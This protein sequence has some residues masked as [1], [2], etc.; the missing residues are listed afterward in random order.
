VTGRGWRVA[1]DRGGTFTDVVATGPDGRVRVSKLLSGEGVEVAALRALFGER[2]GELVDELRLG[3]T[4]ATNALLTRRGSPTALVVTRGH[5]DL[6]AIRHQ[7]RPRIFELFVRK[8]EPLCARVIEVDERTL[9]D[10]TVERE[11]DLP[12][13]RPALEELRAG[14]IRSVAV[15]L[16]HGYLFPEHERHVGALA[17]EVGFDRVTLSSEIAPEI[18]L[19]ARAET[20]AVDGFVTP[21]LEAWIRR[22]LASLPVAATSFMKSSGGLTEAE[23]F[24]GID[25]VLSGPAGGVVACA[26]IGRQLGLSAVL[27]FDMGGTSTDVCRW[28]GELER[29]S[30]LEVGG[31][32]L[33]APVL[34]IVTVAAGGGS[35]LRDL[36]GR[37][38]AGPDSSGATPGPACYGRGGPASLTDANVALG[39]LAPDLFPPVFGPEADAPLDVVAARD[40]LAP[41]GDPAE[42]AAGFVA[43]ANA[44]M[45]AAIS[46]LSTERG[47]DPA[48]HALVAFGGAAPQHACAIAELLGIR[49]VV[50]HPLAGV[51]SACGIDQADRL[52]TRSLPVMEVWDEGLP[53]RLGPRLAAAVEA[54]RAEVGDPSAE[55]ALR[56][57]LRYRGS[58][59]SLPARDAAHFEAAH[60]RLFGFRRPGPVEAVQLR[61]EARS[62]RAVELGVAPVLADASWPSPV[63]VRSVG[64]ADAEGGVAW[65]AT[66]VF[67]R[68]ELPPGRRDGPLLLA[69]P[70]TTILVDPGW[71]AEVDSAGRVLLTAGARVRRPPRGPARDPVRLELF[72]R[73]FMSIA[74]RMGETLRRVA[75]SVNIKERLDYSCAVFDASG[76]LVANA[77][78]IPVHLGAMGETVRALAARLGPELRPGRSW[79]VN[80]PFEG[81]SHLPDITVI[82]PVFAPGERVPFAWVANRG[83]HADVGGITPGSMPPFSR[84]LDEEG[85]RL[86]DLLLVDGSHWRR[87]AVASALATGPHP[88]RD[89]DTCVAD[90]QAQVAANT[91]GARLLCELADREGADAVAAYMG[92]IQDNGDEV[93]Q[94]WLRGWVGGARRFADA[95]DDGTPIRVALTVRPAG[96]RRELVVDFEGTGP[97]TA[98][99]LNAPPAVVRAAVLYVLRCVVDREIPLNEG[100]LRAVRIRIPEGSLLRPPPGAAV[101]GGNVETS[102]RL[103]DVL[104][105][106]LGVAA[107][108]QGTMNNLTFGDAG[109]GYYETVCGGAGAGE[110]RAGTDAVHTHMTNT[111]ITD[112]EVLERRQPV[113]VREFGLR[114]GSGGAGRWPGGRGVRRVL[115]F[116]APLQVSLLSQRRERPPFGLAGGHSGASGRASLERADGPREELAGC[117]AIQVEPG[118]RLVLETPGGGGFGQPSPPPPAPPSQTPPTGD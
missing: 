54:A 110:G 78:H 113:L 62:G 47:H 45:A 28:A 65:H 83:H 24:A 7:A 23:T 79:A 102:Q 70:V 118:D 3:T 38:R 19:V 35:V 93:V 108:S 115:E 14:G 81:G 13:L 103:V 20:A 95:M 49:T 99:N 51:L 18:G 105:G 21:V 82:T 90:L 27:G 4:V 117:F 5:R 43:V 2:A 104:L 26:H 116:R 66:P 52:A 86:R 73:R 48:E 91:L 50:I 76:H 34:D 100:C 57:D 30:T 16:V 112:T 114:D 97:A 80:D 9:P 87:D 36:D 17:R 12:R 6:L 88:A 92:H 106:A 101:V 8:V 85:V 33:R 41:F 72:W 77:P 74:T 53:D 71:A 32:R 22:L 69:D 25:A 58:D 67:R 96:E 60:E 59:T 11:P 40:V 109:R 42:A 64:F 63:A 98:G 107:A 29:R 44:T 31:A 15:A 68:R 75:W 46:E 10:G 89:P 37:F 111:R 1:I 39:R 84:S 56:W 55:V 94:A 61:V